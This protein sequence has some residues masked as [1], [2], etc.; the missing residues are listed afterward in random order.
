LNSICLP[1]RY[2]TPLANMK[3]LPQHPCLAL[4]EISDRCPLILRPDSALG[5]T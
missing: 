2:F 5:P 3:T 1:Q 4:G